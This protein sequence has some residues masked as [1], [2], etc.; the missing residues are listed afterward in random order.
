MADIDFVEFFESNSGD[1]L[2]DGSKVTIDG[3]TLFRAGIVFEQAGDY[4]VFA[5]A[6]GFNG[7]TA[8][9]APIDLSVVG[10][11]FPVVGI[12]SPSNGDTFTAGDTLTLEI[13]ASDT[14]GAIT[15]I[16]ILNGTELLGTGVPSGVANQYL[17]NLPTTYTD[18]GVFNF[19]ARATD[20]RGNSTDSEVVVVG[21]VQGSVPVVTLLEPTSGEQ[22][23]V[24]Q[25]FTIRVRAEDADGIISSVVARDISDGGIKFG[26]SATADSILSKTENPD[27]YV[28]NITPGNPD[29]VE[30]VIIATDEDGNQ[31][32]SVPVQFTIT[33]GVVPSV[34]IDSPLDAAGPFNLGEIITVEMT[35]ER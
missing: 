10:G 28:V 17:F 13:F 19:I 6:T 25:P 7:Q 5:K 16:E 35:A 11:E 1:K 24:D 32:S 15:T 4:K 29:V 30:L 34:S 33:S 23:L 12:T 31:T 3:N 22:F 2:G 9:S 8:I 18:L 21:L 20:D 26:R 14:D 27:E